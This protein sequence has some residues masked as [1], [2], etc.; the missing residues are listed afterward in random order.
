MMMD[1]LPKQKAPKSF[2]QVVFLK[3]LGEKVNAICERRQSKEENGDERKAA[4]NRPS[5]GSSVGS[6]WVGHI[7]QKWPFS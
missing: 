7:P 4:E 1:E 3:L 2:S 5:Q 6:C